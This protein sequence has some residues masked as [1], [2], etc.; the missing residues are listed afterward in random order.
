MSRRPRPNTKAVRR[1][2]KRARRAALKIAQ[3][4]ISSFFSPRSWLPI[5]SDGATRAETQKPR[6]SIR[7]NQ[8]GSGSVAVFASVSTNHPSS[9]WYGMMSSCAPL[10]LVSTFLRNLRYA[11]RVRGEEALKEARKKDRLHSIRPLLEMFRTRCLNM[12]CVLYFL[13]VR[14]RAAEI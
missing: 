9:R 14:I 11:P 12:W 1:R 13:F 7:L 10:S 2:R 5:S 4:H 8:S 6:L 3:W